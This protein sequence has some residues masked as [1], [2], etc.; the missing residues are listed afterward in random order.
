[1]YF[2]SISYI[3]YKAFGFGAVGS[4]IT[5]GLYGTDLKRVKIKQGIELASLMILTSNNLSLKI[6]LLP[7]SVVL[8][9]GF[10]YGYSQRLMVWG[11]WFVNKTRD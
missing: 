4:F 8:S 10:I 9:V 6:R 5:T 1:L 7:K 3:I 2:Q 11:R